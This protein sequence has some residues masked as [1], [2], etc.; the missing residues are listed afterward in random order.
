MDS[1]VLATDLKHSFDIV[2]NF[3]ARILAGTHTHT[4]RVAKAEFVPS[5]TSCGGVIQC[6]LPGRCVILRG[7][8]C[9]S[10]SSQCA[11]GT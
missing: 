6:W 9:A 4:A 7:A 1:L 3:K 8:P 2:N 11:G 10:C 5:Q